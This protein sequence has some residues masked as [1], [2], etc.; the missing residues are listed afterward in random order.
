MDKQNSNEAPVTRG[1][2]PAASVNDARRRFTKT[3]LGAGAVIATLASQPVLG[4]VPYNCTISG[5]ASGNVSTHGPVGNCQ[6]GLSPGY[7]KNHTSDWP[8]PFTPSQR[9]KD[10]GGVSNAL[11]N[12]ASTTGQTLLQV[13]D[14]GGGGTT[15]LARHV[16]GALLNAQQ[17]APNFPLSV[18]QV[19]AIWNEVVNTG[20]YQVNATVIWTVDDVT[21]YLSSLNS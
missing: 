12:I 17:F 9:F 21:N 7:W 13:L 4:A 19:K 1:E 10:A 14:L 6:I 16:V 11:L 20:Q 18:A 8:A 5:H 15:A 3:G 2:M